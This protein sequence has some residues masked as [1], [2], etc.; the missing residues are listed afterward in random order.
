MIGNCSSTHINVSFRLAL[1]V[2]EA[3]A[4]GSKLR[5]ALALPDSWSA[6]ECSLCGSSLE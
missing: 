4:R 5:V 1:F 2:A 6:L 3:G